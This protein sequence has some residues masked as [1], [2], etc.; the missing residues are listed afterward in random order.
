MAE[1][2]EH[3]SDG[4]FVELL[5][6][7]RRGSN[8]SLGHALEACRQYLLLIA[9]RELDEQLKAKGGASDLVQET[10][11]E[12]Q[13]DFEKFTGG[14]QEEMLAWLRRILLNNVHNFRRFW[15]TTMKRSASSE[16]PIPDGSS[17]E[18]VPNLSSPQDSPSQR[19]INNERMAAVQSALSRL[20]DEQREVIILHNQQH[21]SFAAIGDKIGK[22]A[23]AARKLWAR[24]VDR[25]QHE[26]AQE[27]DSS[28]R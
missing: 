1:S 3:G 11:F 16:I 12:A 17:G 25:L 8:Q 20:S 7:A 19:A 13:R 22:S 14:T 18:A 27:D 26:L 4:R 6:D 21:W 24:A 28:S 2:G 23:D 10:F 5:Q 15:L 9:N